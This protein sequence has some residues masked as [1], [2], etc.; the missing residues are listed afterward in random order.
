[1][2]VF[3]HVARLGS[4]TAT[5]DA[6]GVATGSVSTI[7]RQLESHL[8]VTL[9]H[10]S[11]RAMHLTAEGAEYFEHCR[12]VLGEIEDMTQ[13]LR[14]T[15]NI[16]EGRL[17]ID[18]NPEVGSVLLPCISDFRLQYPDVELNIGI[19]GDTDGLIGNGVDCAIVVGEL[20]DSS[21]KRRRLGTLQTITV[22][23][24]GY[25]S[26]FGTPADSDELA[27]HMVVHYTPKRFGTARHL[28][29]A[30]AGQDVTVRTRERICVNDPEVVLK[31]AVDGIGLAQVCDLMAIDHLHYGRLEE[32]L[33]HQRPAALPVAA[34][35]A[36]RRHVPM[37]LRA[38]MDWV[39]A[40]LE[41]RVKRTN[42]P[43]MQQ[44]VAD[45]LR[46]SKSGFSP[47]PMRLPRGGSV[48]QEIAA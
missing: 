18:I 28:R 25:L 36:N 44:A 45:R 30:R 26:R 27:D 37:A 38:F 7:V 5:A 10:R 33:E 41:S 22:A 17:C 19:G 11:T 9:L 35:Y 46:A 20:S 2:S 24:P 32:V 47:Y 42:A 12:R 6:M 31:C 48:G 40:I 8:N 13:R 3:A 23:S 21:L 1:M 43:L 4:F 16:A 14:N 15:Q 34:L 29:F 39:E